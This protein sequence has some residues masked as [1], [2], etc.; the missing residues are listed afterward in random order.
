MTA[1]STT[2]PR[3]PR[4]LERVLALRIPLSWEVFAYAFIFLA[5]FGLRLWDL[6]TRA[7]HHDESIHAQWSWGLLQGN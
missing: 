2:F 4:P 5:G 3:E 7:L 1:S 6:G